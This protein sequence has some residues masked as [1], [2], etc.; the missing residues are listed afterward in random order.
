MANFILCVFHHTKNRRNWEQPLES[1]GHFRVGR[2]MVTP[3]FYAAAFRE[4]ISWI[5]GET[6]PSLARPAGGSAMVQTVTSSERNR[7]A[8][9]ACHS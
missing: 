9:V 7:N 1:S 6:D 3:A 4:S 2:D 5:G 8:G